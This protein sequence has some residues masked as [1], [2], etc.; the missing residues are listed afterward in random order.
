MENL[1]ERHTAQRP[2]IAAFKRAG[3][4]V[5]I[6]V[7]PIMLF[8]GFV[9]HP[10]ILSFAMVTDINAWIAEWRGNFMFHF[11]HLLVLFAVPFI[12]AATVRFMSVAKGSG[13]W[14]GFIGGV[15]GVF[16]AFM[17]AVD[18]GA[19]TLVLTAFQT[20]PDDQFTASKPALQALFDRAGWL[21][22]TWAF[23][24]LPLGVVL[25]VIG[26]LKKGIIPKWQGYCA[27]TGLLLLLNPDIEI[28]SSAGALLMCVGFIPLGLRELSGR[29]P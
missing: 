19:L 22:I 29:L 25:Q 18:K 2:D 14:F 8:A 10:N 9:T 11:G 6:I 4:G 3:A 12:I 24:T 16:G 27:I 1:M 26:M 5:S 23:I 15:L 13:A 28:I 7:F 20:L 17:L 21:W